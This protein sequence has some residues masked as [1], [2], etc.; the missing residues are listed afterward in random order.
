VADNYAAHKHPAVK[1]WLR[2]SPRITLHFNPIGCS[3]LNMVEIF[4]GIITRQAIRRGTFRSAKDLT[5]AIRAFIDAYNDRCQP[6]TWTKDADELLAKIKTVK[7]LTPTARGLAIGWAPWPAMSGRLQLE[8]Q[9]ADDAE[10]RGWDREIERR[11]RI[12]DRIH[13]HLTELGEPAGP[14]DGTP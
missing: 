5:A 6:F 7:E 10:E 13:V 14:P 8:R 11:Q 1:A 2:D 3:W 9:Q 12:A 4:F